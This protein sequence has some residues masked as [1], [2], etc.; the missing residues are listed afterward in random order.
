MDAVASAFGINTAGESLNNSALEQ[1]SG[2]EANTGVIVGSAPWPE[3]FVGTPL[4]AV[5]RAASPPSSDTSV[6]G[7]ALDWLIPTANADTVP[8]SSG[9]SN[10][11]SFT[12]PSYL[13]V[14]AGDGGVGPVNQMVPL[15]EADTNPTL[16]QAD[17]QKLADVYHK[18][19]SGQ[20]NTISDT[21]ATDAQNILLKAGKDIGASGADGQ[22]GRKS[23][24][25][26]HQFFGDYYT[27]TIQTAAEW[28]GVPP[29]IMKA[30][31][32]R[33][34]GFD[35]QAASKDPKSGKIIA[36]G[37]A[38]FTKGTG[39]DYGL[40]G[41]GFDNRT[42]PEASIFAQAKYMVKLYSDFPQAKSEDDRWRLALAAYNAGEQNIRAAMA[43]YESNQGRGLGL[44]DS[45]YHVNVPRLNDLRD[46]S[47]S[48]VINE[49]PAG[50]QFWSPHPFEYA[51]ETQNYVERIMG[52]GPQ[53]SGLV[54]KYSG[55]FTW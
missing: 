48:E 30:Q 26:A 9:G 1:A 51:K 18:A 52:F 49:L 54:L 2:A 32:D 42:D 43:D 16:T 24:E 44:Y 8:S 37:I 34:S 35:Y 14:G 21:E 11:T 19:S 53:R 46:I 41:S 25:A 27:S 23:L 28:Y 33:E 55:D 6:L 45:N 20:G 15:A 39:R 38:Q 12:L 50:T 22:F 17:V 13:S 31:I 29:E 10:T 47:A 4:A 36:V 3:P 40:V 5:S 7:S